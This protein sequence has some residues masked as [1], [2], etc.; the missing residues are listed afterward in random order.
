M[1][2][3]R[4]SNVNTPVNARTPKKAKQVTGNATK[5]KKLAELKKVTKEIDQ[6]HKTDMKRF[7][8]SDKLFNKA[9]KLKQQLG[10][11]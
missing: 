5:I 8:R 10:I 2:T 9:R 3:K 7:E 1:G 6:A 11:D 4:R